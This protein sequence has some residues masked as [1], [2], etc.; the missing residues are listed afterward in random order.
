MKGNKDKKKNTSRIPPLSFIDKLI[1]YCLIILSAVCSF[2]FVLFWDDIRSLIAFK[3][4]EVVAYRGHTSSLLFIPLVGFL[5]LSI[6]IFLI[7][8]LQNRKP[9]FGNTK[10]NYGQAPWAKDCY[11]LFD[12]RRKSVKVNPSIK[13]QKRSNFYIWLAGLL[14]VLIVAVFSFFGRNCLCADN[15]I[16]N[17]N[18]FN[19]QM[20]EYTEQDYLRLTIQNKYVSGYRIGSYWK[21][22]IIIETNDGKIFTFSNGD[23]NRNE[24]HYHENCLNKMLEIKHLFATENISVMGENNLEKVADY[25]EMDDAQTKM[26]YDLFA[27]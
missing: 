22:E 6:I 2:L 12:K 18:A 23:F 14:L 15:R 3:D 1:Y 26:L 7:L 9:I 10:I 5:L 4:P 20:N 8:K 21:Y 16:I 17:Y 25:Y 13:K 11:P 27:N 19:R 24:E